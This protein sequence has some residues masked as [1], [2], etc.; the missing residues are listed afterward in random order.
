MKRTRFLAGLAALAL[1][2][3]A[4]SAVPFG[5]SAATSYAAA[6]AD[7]SVETTDFTK[8]LVLDKNTSVQPASYTFTITG[9]AGAAIPTGETGVLEVL[10]GV[11]SPTI[12]EA[13]F[14][15]A[16]NTSAVLESADNVPADVVFTTPDDK[17]DEKYVSK[18]VSIDFSNVTFTEPGVYRYTIAENGTGEVRTLD[19]Y[20]EDA[21]TT[22]DDG[23]DA[24]KPQLKIA[25]YVM[26]PGEKSDN[27]PADGN[28]PAAQK[29]NSITNHF[30]SYSLSVGKKV[31]GNQGSKDKYFKFTVSITN[32]AAG[33]VFPV[34]GNADA[35]IT[36]NAATTYSTGTN[37]TSL[38]AGA[39]GVS[40]D[41]Y[42]QDG[43]YIVISGL[44][45][46]AHYEVTEAAEDYTAAAVSST[47][48]FAIGSVT[49]DDDVS[50]DIN[51]DDV[52]TGFINTREGTIPTGVVM[53]VAGPAAVGLVLVA[54]IAF[55]T[56][57]SRR[58]DAEEEE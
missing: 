24:G 29:S 14:A 50:G 52:Q 18:T 49:F 4:M 47:N 37:A 11:G 30:D 8:Y 5:A 58:R 40:A 15:V 43:Q 28:V 38:T 57:R 41:F 25:G 17:N 48:T 56:I 9:A 20:V 19:V 13:S 55:L 44:P 1:A 23:A 31:Q 54:G 39:D 51:A 46:E 45:D 2:G 21:G 16:D 53:A 42:L 34:G 35:S 10:A 27:P 12:G 3:A 6:R 26:Y 36:A 22:V 33:A 7:G 32:V